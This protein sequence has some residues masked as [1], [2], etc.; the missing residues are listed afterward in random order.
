M[1]IAANLFQSMELQLNGKTLS[2]CSDHVAEVDT[3]EQRLHKSKSWMDSIGASVNWLQESVED[4][5]NQVSSNGYDLNTAEMEHITDWKDPGFGLDATATIT[6][7]IPKVATAATT[8]QETYLTFTNGGGTAL[9]A[10]NRDA[11]NAKVQPGDYIVFN[12][13]DGQTACRVYAEETSGVVAKLNGANIEV[14]CTLGVYRS[15]ANPPTNVDIQFEIKRPTQSRR[16]T[17]FEIIWKPMCLSAFKYSGALPVGKYE[18]ICTPHNAS[19]DNYKIRAIEA[20]SY[21]LSA[22]TPKVGTTATT[23][24]FEVKDCRFYAAQVVGERVDDMEYYL[25]LENSRLQTSPI[26]NTT[27]LSQEYYNVSPTTYGLTVAFQDVNAGIDPR[28]SPSR[29]KIGNIVDETTGTTRLANPELKLTRMFLQYGGKSFPQPDADPSYKITA[30]DDYTTQRY[31]ETMVNTGAY[32][33]EGGGE[34]IVDWQ[35][36]GAIHYF[37]APKDGQDRSTR[38]TVNTMFANDF[39]NK[40]RLL[41]F[42]HYKSA[43]KITVQRGMVVDVQLID[44]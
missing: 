43:A 21:L 4:R 42:D 9:N 3:L 8:T 41:L 10:A 1:N 44:M 36:R 29:F 7:N 39:A 37:S 32:F 38:L 15:S 20:P 18:L 24:A 23:Y 13:G 31:I 26:Q 19:G 5:I 34:S 28:R 33:S 40:A 35:K 11:I 2:R 25:D 14:L 22:D 16:I 27:T 12:N 17:G 30:S 6:T